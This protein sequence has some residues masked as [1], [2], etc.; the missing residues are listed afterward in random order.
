VFNHPNFDPPNAT[1]GNPAFGQITSAG[2]ARETQF[3]LKFV[4]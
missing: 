1:F 3:A 2:D 4:F